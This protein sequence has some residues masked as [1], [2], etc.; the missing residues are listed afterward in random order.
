MR[1]IKKTQNLLRFLVGRRPSGTTTLLNKIAKENDVYVLVHN[2]EMTNHFDKKVHS[3]IYAPDT[4]DKLR[5]AERKPILIDNALF[6][7]MLTNLLLENGSKEEIIEHQKNTLDTISEL[8]SLSNKKNPHIGK[9][10]R[11]L[12]KNIITFM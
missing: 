7:E 1:I 8:I 3:K 9:K 11:I 4:L 5:G 6:Q 2:M 12:D 10:F